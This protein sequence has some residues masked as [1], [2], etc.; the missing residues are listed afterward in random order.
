[1]T[2]LNMVTDIV[3][4]FVTCPDCEELVG[5]CASRS[6]DRPLDPV[7]QPALPR[8][9]RLRTVPLLR[10]PLSTHYMIGPRCPPPW[11]GWNVQ[12]HRA[13][14]GPAVCDTT[15]VALAC[16]PPLVDLPRHCGRML[17]VVQW[18]PLFNCFDMHI[19]AAAHKGRAFTP[20][21]VKS[22]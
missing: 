4:R 17:F 13:L 9:P 7:T 22:L 8:D 3:S 2:S 6:S 12:L 1:M 14:C 16:M 5:G 18:S 20:P 19:N 11:P 15:T 21:L 10:L